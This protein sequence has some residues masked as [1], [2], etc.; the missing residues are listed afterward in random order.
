MRELSIRL[1]KLRNRAILVVLLMVF[2]G[3]ISKST[4]QTD[5]AIVKAK[6]RL[7]M[8]TL[9]GPTTYF[10][11]GRG[12]NGFDYLL[13]KAFADSLG[14]ELEVKV[15]PTLRRLL[16][17]VGGPQ[18]DFAAANLVKTA[19]RDKSLS[20]AKPYLEVTQKLIYRGGSK[21]PRSLDRLEGELVVIADSSHSE[22][23]TKLKDEHPNLEWREQDNAEMSDLIR[24]VHDGEIS[25]SVVD[26]LSYLI[27][28]HIYPKARSAMNISEPQPIA[29][30]FPS[31]NDGTVLAAANAFLEDYIAS[32][33]LQSLTDQ[34]LAQTENFSA[35]DSHRLGKLV[36]NRL[37]K[38]EPLFRE[39]A[40]EFGVDWHLLAAVAYQESHW[41]PKAKSPT[42]VRG[43]MMLTLGTAK[44]MKVENRL[45]AAQSMK[46]GAAYLLK[47]KARLPTRILDPD[48]TLFA[49]AA[50]NV[51]FGHLEDA[52]VLTVRNGK[53]P[54]SWEDVRAHL[55]LLSKKEFYSTVKYGYARGGEP[56]LYVD[57]IQY[58]KTYLQL[59][60]LSRQDPVLDSEYEVDAAAPVD[61]DNALPSL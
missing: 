38:Y 41:N 60:S 7:V 30:A 3:Y 42:G 33:E 28:R 17:S 4:Q 1:R 61:W 48:R 2:A 34:L 32:G 6:G 8:L 5:L 58:Y 31:H 52:R 50:Y 21:R 19:V 29:W 13:S 16:L 23:L 9:P 46:G 44:E 35:S 12:K 51:G 40:A 26:S 57:N 55:P 15:V 11:D 18:G 24:K 20:F 39:T 45:D 27:N 47:L 14:V 22:N 59:Y 37:P 54:D 43:L 25:Y 56:V 10:E 36:A 49:L 53:N